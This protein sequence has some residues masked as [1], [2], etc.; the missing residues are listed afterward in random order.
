MPTTALAPG[1]IIGGDRAA[2]PGRRR[3][4]HHAVQ[5]P[6]RPT[7]PA[8]SA[9]RS[10]MG[11]TVVSSRRRRTR[12]RSSSSAR[13]STRPASRPA[14]STSS[15]ARRP[16]PGEALV[17]SPRRRHGQLHR[18]DRRRR[19][20]SARSAAATMKRLLLEL[21]GKGAGIVFD[22]ADLETAVGT[23]RAACG[24]STPARSAPRRP[25]CIVPA[26]HLRPARRAGSA[27]LPAASR[28]ATRSSAT[29]S[30]ARSSPARTATASRA[31]SQSGA[32]EGGTIVAGGERPDLDAGFYVAP[33]AA[34]RLQAR[35]E[36]SCR[37]RSSA[38]WSSSCRSTTR[39]R[40]S[41][42]PTAPSSA[43]T[44]TCS[45]PTRRAAY[46]V[47]QQLRTG[48]V[49]INTAQRNHEAP[50]RRLQD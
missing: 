32:D 2:G 48:N 40:P 50:V 29:P 35:H 24:R 28:S 49:G 12:S 25:A 14:S 45:R 43:C 41:P 8:R 3:R 21:G 11:N 5:L 30:S 33:D 9:P 15:P 20:A 13:S 37:R 4:V 47:A 19:S 26:R 36:A 27:Q 10:A 6:D 42:S 1:G 46:G 39:T 38:R 7:W 17:D 23:H 34:R 22:D 44:T 16:R 31:T 18:L